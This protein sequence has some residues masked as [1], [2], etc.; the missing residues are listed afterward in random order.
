MKHVKYG[1]KAVLVDDEA[2]DTLLEY[3][4][5]IAESGDADTVTLKVIGP[6]GN[7]VEASLLLTASTDIMVES[8]NTTLDAPDNDEAVR[9]MR[10]RL[11]AENRP[12]LP[13]NDPPWQQ[14]GLDD[15]AET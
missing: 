15:V 13:E 5:L 4:R 6:D 2:A 10:A 7:T 12:A 9:M 11:D 14:G 3:A 8:T 1:D